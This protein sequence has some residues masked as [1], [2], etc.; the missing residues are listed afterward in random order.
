MIDQKIKLFIDFDGT[1]TRED[2]GESIFRN[3][4]DR[5]KVDKIIEDLLSDRISAK[6]SWIDLCASVDKVDVNT[7]NEFIYKMEVDPGMYK[8]IQFCRDHDIQIIVLSDG[9]DYY[10]DMI[11]ERENLTG[12][13]YFSNHLEISSQNKLVPEFPFED[14]NSRNT[15]NC[16]KNHIITNSSDEDITMYIGDG[17]S[18]KDPALYCDFIFAK[19][20]LLKYCEK[21]RVSYFPY[22]TFDDVIDILAVL[23]KKKKLKKRHQAGLKRREAYI[24]E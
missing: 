8:L 5:S 22:K 18:D 12:L 17:N 15:A 13:K 1:I 6:Q 23:L 4:G 11:F 16:K 9:F 14:P 21:E 10:I 19:R 7:L 2:V 24:T 3:F 20:S